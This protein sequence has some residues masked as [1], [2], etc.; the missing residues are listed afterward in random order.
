MWRYREA[1]PIE[2]GEP[3]VTFE[4]GFTPLLE[5]EIGEKKVLVKQEQLSPTGS[6]KDRGAS[7]LISK[8]K[9]LGISKVVED[10]SGNAGCAMA[11]YSAAAG[12]DCDIYV[13]ASTSPGKLSQIQ[14]YGAALNKIPG[15]RQDTANA[16]QEAAGKYYY[17]SHY[18]NPFFNHGT[19]TIAFEV[20]EQLGW[21]A[22]DVMITTVGHGSQ[23][24]GAYLGFKELYHA[25]I[26]GKIPRLIGVQA[27]NC[28][29]LYRAYR[30]QLSA[31]P[32]VESIKTAAEGIAIASPLRGQQILEA[33]K[34]TGGE[35]LAVS[36]AEIKNAL[37]EMCRK[38]YYI[39]PTSAAAVAG[40]KQYLE[41]RSL[42]DEI[43]VT[44]FT[45]SGLKAGNKMLEI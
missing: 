22:P 23:L 26:I 29:P 3:V 28:A 8:V 38:G 5:I 13:P 16:V 37:L 2:V 35:F 6:F 44:L 34:S 32:A 24:L 30:E 17:A 12:I 14:M 20:A 45:G 15:S 11:A 4:E 18:W 1:I 19:K 36:E 41:T 42:K 27:V 7:V 31:V 25:G 9:A 21:K 39:E 43:I 10:S 40:V 33:A